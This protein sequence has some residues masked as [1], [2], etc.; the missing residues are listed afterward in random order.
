MTSYL[1]LSL[2]FPLAIILVWNLC[3]LA[4]NYAVARKV[5]VPLIVLP[6]SP[7]NPTW[8]LISDFCIPIVKRIP[9]G[10]GNF[11]RYCH[12]G[13]EFYDR[14]RTHLELGDVFMIVTPRKNILYICNAEALAEVIE[15]RNEFQRPLEVLRKAMTIPSPE[16]NSYAF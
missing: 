15:R 16:S 3:K 6:I 14:N 7:E 2:I 13:W 11:T 12:R 1:L 9:F 10:S 8:V 4:A 5:G